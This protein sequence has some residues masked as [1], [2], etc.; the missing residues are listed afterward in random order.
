MKK[1]KFI[2]VGEGETPPQG[3]TPQAQETPPA[4]GETPPAGEQTPPTD[5]RQSL[6]EDLQGNDLVKGS[7]TLE[8]LVAKATK[9]PDPIDP[10][11]YQLPEGIDTP[12]FRQAA[13]EANLSGEGMGKLLSVF[14]AQ[15][16]AITKAETAIQEEATNK[17][18]ESWGD[19]RQQ[20]LA[21]ANTLIQTFDESGDMTKLLN[22]TGA[23]NHPAVVEFIHNIASAMTEDGFLQ[24][25]SAAPQAK[26]SAANVLYPEQGN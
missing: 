20:N 25:K 22:Q 12:E 16:Q 19:N 13:S 7:E 1:H 15:Q 10:T 23:G 9:K 24:V 14:Q 8:A 26:K 2:W 11:S 6:S 18:L 17:I 4:E 21:Q 3:E 5:W